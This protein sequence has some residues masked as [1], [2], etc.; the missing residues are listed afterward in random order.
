[1]S[2]ITFIFFSMKPRCLLFVLSIA[3]VLAAP[4]L[5]QPKPLSSRI[6]A[7]TVYADRAIVTRVAHVDLASGQAE[8]SFEKLP[9]NLV[10]QSLQV[11]GHGAAQATI[12]DVNARTTFVEATPDARIKSLEDELAAQQKKVRVLNDRG[13]VLASSGRCWRKSKRR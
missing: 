3:G 12:L 1:L 11:S 13:S 7:A 9:A 5:A 2:H 4:C 10:D 6:V 8:L